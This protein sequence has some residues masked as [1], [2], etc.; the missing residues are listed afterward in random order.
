VGQT[1]V[2]AG[3]MIQCTGRDSPVVTAHQRY[4]AGVLTALFYGLGTAVPLVVGAAVGL[5]WTLPPKVLGALMAFGAGT[6]V[7]AASEELFGPAFDVGP[8]ALVGG[9]LLAGATVYV[10]ATQQLGTR[11]AVG[12][13]GWALMFGAILDGVPENTALGVSLDEGGLALLVAIAVGNTPEAIGSASILKADPKIGARRGILMWIGVGVVLVVVT[14]LAHVAADSVSSSSIAVAQAFAGG[15]TIAV[16]AD[17]LMPEAFKE[18]GWW[19][20]LA[21]TFGFFAAYL[22]G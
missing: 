2:S 8:T 1:T 4:G 16:L 15:A 17:T 14:V 22:L 5:R 7:A 18:A 20:G 3:H 12:A 10:V 11:Y 21:T 6:M 19:T 9:A 13:A